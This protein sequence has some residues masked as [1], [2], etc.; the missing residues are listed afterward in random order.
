[1][2]EFLVLLGALDDQPIV[3]YIAAFT[4]IF[5]AVYLLFMVQ[6]TIFGELSDFLKGLGSKLTDVDRMEALTLA[7]L[8]VLTVA[9]GLFPALVLDLIALPVA[10]ILDVVEGAAEAAAG[11]TTGSLP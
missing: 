2:G 1:V 8:V 10:G 9:L 6:N 4:I 7:P 3:G 5:A 11:T